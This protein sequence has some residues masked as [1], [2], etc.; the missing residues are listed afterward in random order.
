MGEWEG[1]NWETSVSIRRR[2][3]KVY[4]G[5]KRGDGMVHR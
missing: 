3:E 1:K 4:S 2:G 5:F